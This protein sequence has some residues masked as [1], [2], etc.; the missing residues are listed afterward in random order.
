MPV[1]RALARGAAPSHP[2][3]RKRLAVRPGALPARKRFP[4]HPYALSRPPPPRTPFP[5]LSNYNQ[6]LVTCIEDLREKREELNRSLLRDEEEKAK[7]QKELTTLTERLSRL[8]EDIARKMQ[9]R[10][11]APRSPFP[12]P[13]RCAPAAKAKALARY[14]TPLPAGAP[15]IRPNHPGDGGGVHEDP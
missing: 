14:H 12:A 4:R 8:N 9:V 2:P 3:F 11:G 6:E 15:R 7:I 10:G 13:L 5:S 1:P